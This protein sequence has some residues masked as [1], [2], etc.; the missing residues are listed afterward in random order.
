MSYPVLVPA[1]NEPRS[2]IPKG[3]ALLQTRNSHALV[4]HEPGA[5][6]AECR[7]RAAKGKGRLHRVDFDT[8]QVGV[9]DEHDGELRPDRRGGIERIE[10]WT[11]RRLHRGELIA[12]DNRDDRRAEAPASGTAGTLCRGVRARPSGWGSESSARVHGRTRRGSG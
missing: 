7:D 3:A 8:V 5:S 9:Y 2:G 10:R 6:Y 11:S 4:A 1:D 12:I